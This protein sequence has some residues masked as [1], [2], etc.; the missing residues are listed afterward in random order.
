MSWRAVGY[1]IFVMTCFI[2]KWSEPGIKTLMVLP[3]LGLSIITG[4]LLL[5]LV[6]A[7]YI[8]RKLI[9][10][11]S[12]MKKDFIGK[13][14]LLSAKLTHARLFPATERYFYWYDYFM[15]GIPVGLRGR[16]GNLLS[17]DN[18]PTREQSWYQRCWFTIDPTYYLDRGS[19]DRGLEEKMHIFLRSMG[20]DP[21][22][23]PY[24]YLLSVPKFLGIQK[25]AVSYWYLYSSN[26]QLSAMII[27]INNAFNEKRN[28]FSRITGDGLTVDN[29]TNW[30][31]TITASVKGSKTHET[32]P[33]QFS[34]SSPGSKN[35]KTTWD[36]VI[37][38]SP[39]VKVGGSMT[40]KSVDPMVS[41]SFQ[42]IMTSNSPDGQVLV[43]S[44]LSS[45]G[46]PIDPVLASGWT[47]ARFIARWTHAGAAS[48]IRIVKEATR[49]RFRSKVLALL[50]RPEVRPGSIPRNGTESEQALELPFRQYL[51]E[52]ASHTSFPVTIKYI[53]PKALHFDEI[54]FRSPS[55]T[56]SSAEPS[57]TIQ[58]LS[59]RF[60]TSFP[61][62]ST[63]ESA[64]AEE[65]KPSPT[66]ADQSS[67]RLLVLNHTLLDRVL[68]TAGRTLDTKAAKVKSNRS[69]NWISA[70]LHI[71]I[72]ALRQ[73][74]TETFMDR[75]VNHHLSSSMQQSYQT[76]TIHHLLACR[77]PIDSHAMVKLCYISARTMFVYT[78]C[79]A[80]FS[81]WLQKD[82]AALMWQYSITPGT[83][84]AVYWGWDMVNNYI[85]KYG[86]NPFAWG[87]GL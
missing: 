3:L 55:C 57:V 59:H 65:T 54:I 63:A 11:D 39:F 78:L 25:S 12:S 84:T 75:F 66:N 71:L 30:S 4:S 21:N 40:T 76:S 15:I 19:G 31:T 49:I 87:N 14:L 6:M 13:P 85:G 60:Y 80:A 56:G 73:P 44:R 27:E 77:L 43:T 37:F 35:Y 22:E 69:V 45:W 64:F 17:I 34:S 41:L 9:V 7:A 38:A 70:F 79:W 24:A 46:E 32:M 42:S 53:P 86:V 50:E 51:S 68:T 72:C 82:L 18:P 47:I 62:H 10:L 29:A 33:I 1:T 81:T 48:T 23:F 58:P 74:S 16:I 61:Q 36:K 52:L 67:C 8:R 83:S 20:E 2:L 26:R 28:V 5:W